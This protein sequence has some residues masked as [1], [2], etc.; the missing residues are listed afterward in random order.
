MCANIM[1]M[2]YWLTNIDLILK[3]S[4]FYWCMGYNSYYSTGRSGFYLTDSIHKVL[5]QHNDSLPTSDGNDKFMRHYKTRKAQT[6][7]CILI[8]KNQE[9]KLH[10]KRS[11][12]YHH[13]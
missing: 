10:H 5:L 4:A 11:D 12:K 9:L 3:C 1:E 13:V 6:F 2:R 7:R 8:R